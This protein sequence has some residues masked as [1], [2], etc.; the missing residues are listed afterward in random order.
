M[1]QSQQQSSSPYRRD[2]WWGHNEV[3]TDRP[4]GHDPAEFHYH[5]ERTQWIVHDILKS[6]ATLCC[7]IALNAAPYNPPELW[8][9]LKS[10][11]P[12]TAVDHDP[13]ARHYERAVVELTEPEFWLPLET[14]ENYCGRPLEYGQRTHRTRYNPEHGY[15]VGPQL[16]DV[17][18]ETFLEVTNMVLDHLVAV[19]EIGLSKRERDTLE[20]DAR[21]MKQAGDRHDDE[22]LATIIRDATGQR[23]Q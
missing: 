7:P 19:K 6:V 3:E 21:R 9:W 13:T 17:D 4:T 15:P 12:E 14:S 8:T 18:Y 5:T 2:D 1:S 16:L 22:I 10:G 23:S 11:N 20:R